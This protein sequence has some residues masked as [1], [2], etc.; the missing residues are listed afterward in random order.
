MTS[1]AMND[2]RT[3]RPPEHVKLERLIPIAAQLAT[4]L[5]LGSDN[6]SPGDHAI[7]STL[8]MQ[9][10]SLR[11]HRGDLPTAFQSY[12]TKIAAN[13]E[14]L[15]PSDQLA[16]KIE[17]LQLELAERSCKLCLPRRKPKCRRDLPTNDR[18]HHGGNCI[19]PIKNLFED[20][21]QDVVQLWQLIFGDARPPDL[22]LATK[23]LELADKLA[24]HKDFSLTGKAQ[25]VDQP[26]PT[27]WIAVAFY[28]SAFDWE[29]FILLPYLMYHEIVCH[30]LQDVYDVNGGNVPRS[31]RYPATPACLWSEGW[32]DTVSH[33]LAMAWLKRRGARHRIEGQ[34]VVGRAQ[35]WIGQYHDARY[36]EGGLVLST[37]RHY[38]REAFER[39]KTKIT[40]PNF[41][42]ESALDLLI[43]FSMLLNACVLPNVPA[44]ATP[45]ERRTR[46]IQALE[47]LAVGPEPAS[48]RRLMEGFLANRD[49]RGLPA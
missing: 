29:Q 48:V 31:A 15:S 36:G 11:S 46:I 4:A 28:D 26:H 14:G 41:S 13:L 22:H 21:K 42:E 25:I 20:I 18:V 9:A 8:K 38:G 44:G 16:S 32:M 27:T 43:R 34:R 3:I 10:H 24:V 30:G 7:R 19:A 33:Y 23:H 40:T 17:T 5:H 45:N 47:V 39:I 37:E 2:L 6:M 35:N 1:S 49:F 12:R